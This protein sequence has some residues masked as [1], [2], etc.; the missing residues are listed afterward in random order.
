MNLKNILATDIDKDGLL[1]GPNIDV[2]TNILTNIRFYKFNSIWW[3]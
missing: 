1:E 3:Y 2:Y